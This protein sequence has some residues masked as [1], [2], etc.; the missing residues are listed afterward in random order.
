MKRY[1][2]FLVIVSLV[3]TFTWALPEVSTRG[4]R[5]QGPSVG[6]LAQ[7]SDKV[8]GFFKKMNRAG[9]KRSVT[10]RPLKQTNT[11][12]YPLAADVSLTYKGEHR[13]WQ[14]GIII[15]SIVELVMESGEVKVINVVEW[16]S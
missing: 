5:W 16:S 1:S 8:T 14:Q 13:A 6:Q 11:R 10:I 9:A 2:I 3:F 4:V 12:T 7:A 15:D